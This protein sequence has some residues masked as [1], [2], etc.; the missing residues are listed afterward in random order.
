MVD[1][2]ILFPQFRDEQSA[3]KYPFA[4]TASLTA[5]TG[6]KLDPDLFVDVSLFGVNVGPRVYL[7]S[8]TVTPQD[9]VFT[10]GD[11]KTTNAASGRCSAVS[12]PDNGVVALDDEYG[13]PAGM[14]LAL[15]AERDPGGTLLAP[16][17]LTKLSAFP[18]G[19]HN[20]TLADAEFVAT[21]VIPAAEPGVRGLSID[22]VGLYTGDVWLVGKNG[23][24]LRAKTAHTIR[25]DIISE[26][27]FKRAACAPQTEFIGKN[28]LQTLNN[29]GP[30]QYGN[31]TFT[32]DAGIVDRPNVRIYPTGNSLVF[33]T[34]GP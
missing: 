11:V 32:A 13:R 20:F 16:T 21:T 8:I 27:L 15:A 19:T 10:V 5:D 2:R 23:I 4:D 9:L 22:N 18:R 30:D 3:S 34:I 31:F 6:A 1:A 29:C 24:V 33:S 14:L 17:S 25:V 28:Y 12:P 26:P 7:S